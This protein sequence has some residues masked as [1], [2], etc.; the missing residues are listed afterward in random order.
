[1]ARS[2][3]TNV[4]GGELHFGYLPPHGL[5]LPAWGEK[6]YEADVRTLILAKSRGIRSTKVEALQ[7]DIENGF[8]CVEAIPE[9]TCS[10]SS[11][12]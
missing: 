4:S 8:I 5:T 3:V 1:M 6:I 11:S 9:P 7:H 12:A 10:S 2:R